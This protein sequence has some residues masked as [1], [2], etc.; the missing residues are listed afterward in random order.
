VPVQLEIRYGGDAWR[1]RAEQ[2]ASSI[3]YDGFFITTRDVHAPGTELAFELRTADDEIAL[4]GSGIV[5]WVRSGAQP[6]VGLQFTR[7]DAE[8]TQRVRAIVDRYLAAR[9]AG[10]DVSGPRID[11]AGPESRPRSSDVPW[12]EVPG[13]PAAFVTPPPPSGPPASAPPVLEPPASEPPAS[14]PPA[15]EPP[16]SEPPSAS[17]EPPPPS[18]PPPPPQRGRSGSSRLLLAVGVSLV[19]MILALIA[20]L[21]R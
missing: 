2:F 17:P 13:P 9:L 7:L 16:S 12:A 5:R 18:P 3:S 15:F 20:A 1:Q 14:E 8:N 6:G 11:Q 4:Q 21:A 19:A 10:I